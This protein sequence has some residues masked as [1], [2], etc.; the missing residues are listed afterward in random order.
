MHSRG[1]RRRCMITRAAPRCHALSHDPGSPPTSWSTPTPH[2]TTHD[3]AQLP[4]VGM[5]VSR[6][7][8]CCSVRLAF[9]YLF[10]FCPRA[11]HSM[12]GVGKGVGG[13]VWLRRR[14]ILHR[15]ISRLKLDNSSTRLG[16]RSPV[17]LFSLDVFSPALFRGYV[18]AA[19]T[20]QLL[21]SVHSLLGWLKL[22]LKMIFGR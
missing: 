4:C 18:Y 8:C 22:G 3:H 2:H 21:Y 10:L 6:C 5:T 15:C 12:G 13:G 1:R 14:L 20:C 11:L 16:C 19:L 7:S 9:C 17:S